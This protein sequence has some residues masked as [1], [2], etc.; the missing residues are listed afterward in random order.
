MEYYSIAALVVGICFVSVVWLMSREIDRVQ[1]DLSCYRELATQQQEEIY[2]LEA[3]RD[4]EADQ[5]KRAIEHNGLVHCE[6]CSGGWEAPSDD[7]IFHLC[8]KCNGGGWVFQP[9]V[10]GPQ[11]SPVFDREQILDDFPI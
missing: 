3:A 6:H 5:F 8:P 4:A 1:H 9:P 7:G 10:F 2:T 11:P